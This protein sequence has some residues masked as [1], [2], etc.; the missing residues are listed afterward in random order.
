L[1]ESILSPLI[2]KDEDHEQ[3]REPPKT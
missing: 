1:R 3:K 2:V